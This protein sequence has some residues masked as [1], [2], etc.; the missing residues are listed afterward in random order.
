MTVG[1]RDRLPAG[2]ACDSDWLFFPDAGGS[3]PSFAGG[4]CAPGTLSVPSIGGPVS[5]ENFHARVI[6]DCTANWQPEGGTARARLGRVGDANVRAAKPRRT[7]NQVRMR[8]AVSGHAFSAVQ[9]VVASDPSLQLREIRP[10][11]S[12]HG[13]LASFARRSD[14]RTAIAIAS[15][16]LLDQARLVAVFN[17]RNPSVRPDVTIDAAY[18][19]DVAVAIRR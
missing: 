17:R 18:V 6:G 8:I 9:L 19:D 4:V 5:G 16:S 13:A 7:G 14:G 2:I 12:A 15:P 10:L 1:L 11:G 3:A